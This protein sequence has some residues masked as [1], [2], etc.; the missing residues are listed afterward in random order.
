MLGITNINKLI[1][2]LLI[3]SYSLYAEV[4]KEQSLSK[5]INK[6]S[7][8]LEQLEQNINETKNKKYKLTR[9]L[10]IV[11]VENKLE[12]LKNKDKNLLYIS[13]YINSHSSINE[14]KLCYLRGEAYQ[15][16]NSA[17]MLLDDNINIDKDILESLI[18]E[19]TKII[20][21]STSI[22]CKPTVLDLELIIQIRK[23]LDG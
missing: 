18:K 7:F 23:E 16:A 15:Q 14:N 9:N 3:L 21:Q 8:K 17:L 22:T 6:T 19:T 5:E 12:E 13:N 11:Q 4:T 2:S 10:K 1:L 20:R